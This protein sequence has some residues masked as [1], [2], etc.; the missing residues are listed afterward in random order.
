ML[1]KNFSRKIEIDTILKYLELITKFVAVMIIIATVIG[2]LN[3]YS[4][5][6]DINHLFLFSD[7]IGISYA[8]VSALVSYFL[9]VVM[10]AVGFLSPFIMTIFLF[11]ISNNSSENRNQANKKTNNNQ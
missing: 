7:V 11:L 6:K 3:I 10:I 8:S 4:Y 1:R 5:L 9:F 2:G